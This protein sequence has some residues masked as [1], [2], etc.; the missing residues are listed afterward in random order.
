MQCATQVKLTSDAAA[1][2]IKKKLFPHFKNKNMKRSL[3]THVAAAIIIT[4][5]MMAMYATVQQ[6][7]RSTANDPQLQ[8]ARDISA[9]LS[10]NKVITNMLPDDTIDLAN[11]LGTFVA[12]YDAKGDAMQSTGL[13]DGKMPQIPAGVF[14]YAKTNKEDVLTWQPRNGV[15]MAMVVEAVSSPQVAYVAVGRSLQEVEER[16]SNL[17]MMILITWLACMGVLVVHFALQS[18]IARKNSK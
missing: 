17:T 7:H 13:L 11:S 12:L 15:R 1:G 3:I 4:G 14:D 10:G 9:R 6:A 16:E 5:V 2:L 8:L 18:R